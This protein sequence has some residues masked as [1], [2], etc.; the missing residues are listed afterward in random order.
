MRVEETLTWEIYLNNIS[1]VYRHVFDLL[2]RPALIRRTG[3]EDS[4]L[5]ILKPV[6]SSTC[7]SSFFWIICREKE[8]ANSVIKI[9]HLTKKCIGIDRFLQVNDFT[10]AYL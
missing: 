3:L 5:R 1:E 10:I 4:R 9:K 2:G 7:I 8:H 6:G